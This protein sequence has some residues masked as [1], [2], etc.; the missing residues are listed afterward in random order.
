MRGNKRLRV[1][2]RRDL[3]MSVIATNDSLNFEGR[4]EKLK[5]RVAAIRSFGA[6][7]L[8][9]AYVAAGRFDAFYGGTPKRG[10]KPW[11]VAAGAFI[12]REAGGYASEINGMAD[13]VYNQNI[14]A[15]NEYI[16]GQVKD[17]L[18]AK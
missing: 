7:A 16:Y 3:N 9:L 8:E 15:G 6:T 14:L 13:H 2:G 17:I 11:D 18:N 12:V 5:P 1:S 4:Y 10:P